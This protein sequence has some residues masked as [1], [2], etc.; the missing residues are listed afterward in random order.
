MTKNLALKNSTA[1]VGEIIKWQGRYWRCLK[2]GDMY[3][4]FEVVENRA[5]WVR[6]GV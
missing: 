6:E 2:K 3:T 1:R 5:D 4:T